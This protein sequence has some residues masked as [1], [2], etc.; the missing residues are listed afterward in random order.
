MGSSCSVMSRGHHQAGWLQVSRPFPA[1]PSK[2]SLHTSEMLL[3]EGQVRVG[4]TLIFL[5]FV[6]RSTQ[7][8]TLIQENSKRTIW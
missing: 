1:L 3:D 5:H 7:L 6:I 2:S 8:D 4:M